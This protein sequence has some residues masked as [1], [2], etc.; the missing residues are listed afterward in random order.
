[1]RIFLTLILALAPSSFIQA[2][3]SQD[4]HPSAKPSNCADVVRI[5]EYAK[6]SE[7][8]NLVITK[9]ESKGP[10]GQEVR[11]RY[12]IHANTP[13]GETLHLWADG[14]VLQKQEIENF[15]LTFKKPVIVSAS[16]TDVTVEEGPWCSFPATT[17]KAVSPKRQNPAVKAKNR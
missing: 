14:K 13:L 3:H 1:M 5:L 7:S 15:S 12:M 16:V 8:A 2:Q 6:P 11:F 10:V 9:F 17:T 4:G